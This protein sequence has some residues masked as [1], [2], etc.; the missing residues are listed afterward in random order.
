M[1]LF[2]SFLSQTSWFKVIFIFSIT[3]SCTTT[4]TRQNYLATVKD[5][6]LYLKT[7][8][9]ITTDDSLNQEMQTCK[10]VELCVKKVFNHYCR[11]GKQVR[12]LSTNIVAVFGGSQAGTPIDVAAKMRQVAALKIRKLVSQ[13]YRR[14]P[15]LENSE[16]R[17]GFVTAVPFENIN[18]IINGFRN[19]RI[20]YGSYPVM[21]TTIGTDQRIV[22][23]FTQLSEYPIV[24]DIH[25]SNPI[26]IKY[27]NALDWQKNNCANDKDCEI[28]KNLGTCS[29]ANQIESYFGYVNPKAEHNS[30]IKPPHS[31]HLV[32]PTYPFEPAIFANN[33]TMLIPAKTQFEIFSQDVF[34]QSFDQN[35]I[36]RDWGIFGVKKKLDNVPDYLNKMVPIFFVKKDQTF[37]ITNA[38]NRR[39]D[40]W[41]AYIDR[42]TSVK[43]AQDRDPDITKYEVSLDL[44]PFCA[45]GRPISDLLTK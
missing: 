44:S 2:R 1:S 30:G 20:S 6:N 43:E 17:D 12:N 22:I 24:G 34:L 16:K 10:E 33:F 13:Y 26:G 36:A 23:G 40:L 14:I 18:D 5:I 29:V 25:S 32:T 45:Y 4:A 28:F 42:F 19:S 15:L 9:P 37:D 38:I 3:L 41:I 11:S 39:R 31:L 21:L 8:D 7:R 27:C 35:T